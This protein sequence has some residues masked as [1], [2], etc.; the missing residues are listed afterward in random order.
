VSALRTLPRNLPWGLLLGLGA[1]LGLAACNYIGKQITTQVYDDRFTG[2][3]EPAGGTHCPEAMPATL[4]T[5]AKDHSVTFAPNDGVLLL[6]GTIGPDGSV[7]AS[8]NTAPPK[9]PPHLLSLTG[10][11]GKDGFSG[12]Y[13]TPQCSFKAEL[14]RP[15]PLPRRF[16]D[17]KNVLGIP[18]P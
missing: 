18:N 16:V 17:P 15:A 14:T 11:L 8:L 4:V 5:R 3:L 1:A 2:E 13:E 10:Q 9:H 7:A 6:R 12:R